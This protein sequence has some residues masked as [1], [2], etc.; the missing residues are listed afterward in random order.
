[1]Q[2]A[3]HKVNC[4]PYS[5][6]RQ[7]DHT[8]SWG[9]AMCVAP[10]QDETS[11]FLQCELQFHDSGNALGINLTSENTTVKKPSTSLLLCM[12]YLLV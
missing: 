7:V 1:M 4:N 10:F 6:Q 2:A 3:L 11:L 8:T 5:E 12:T 9:T